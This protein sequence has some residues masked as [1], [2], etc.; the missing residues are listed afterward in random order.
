M[1]LQ[2]NTT[3]FE[4]VTWNGLALNNRIVMAP[5]T[6]SRAIGAVPNELM[7]VYYSQRASAGLIITEGIAPSPNALGYSRIPGIFADDQVKGWKKI[8]D[9]VHGKGGKIFSQLM[10]T[11]RI[12]HPENMPEGSKVVAPSAI[13]AAGEMWTDSSGLQPMAIPEAMETAD[14]DHVVTEFVQAAKNAVE[15]GFDGVE[16]HG[17]NGYLLEQF[18]N[19]HANARTDEYGGSIAN[20]IRLVLKVVRSVA[21]AIG[22]GKTGIRLSPY[23]TFNDMP[24]YDEIFDTYQA[25]A[26]ELSKLDI[27][28]VHLVELA[29]VK[30]EEG[31]RLL[32]EIRADFSNI[33]IINGGYT[34]E[35]AE[36]ALEEN[37]ADLIA[38][39]V[40]FIANPDLPE[41]IK[42]NILLTSPDPDTFYTPGEKGYT[43]YP[44][45]YEKEEQ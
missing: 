19:P 18:L 31:R 16:I 20:R 37:Q 29:A 23:N 25:L 3:L 10:H 8:T 9:A 38:F 17:A 41:R 40:P 42:Q 12:A 1:K 45:H 44:F 26:K 32:K 6:R 43:D 14:I 4:P 22:K 5:M 21:D 13:Q 7:A 30:H 15:A 11:G 2:S 28:Y 34:G 33:L 24:G 35:R 36:K 39:G 27:L